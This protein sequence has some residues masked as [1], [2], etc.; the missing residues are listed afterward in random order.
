[1]NE[2]TLPKAYQ[3]KNL[4]R[5]AVLVCVT[6][7]HAGERLIQGGANI[8]AQKGCSLLV[9]SIQESSFHYASKSDALE[10]LFQVSTEYNA[11]MSVFYGSDP[12]LVA[13]NYISRR[14]VE[15]IVTGMPSDGGHFIINIQQ[16]FPDIPLSIIPPQGMVD[17]SFQDHVTPAEQE[18]FLNEHALSAVFARS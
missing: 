16:S 7:Q 3:E 18:S 11:D 12:I 8:A 6:D 10:H 5:P 4:H 15:H 2:K 1:M 9:L 17:I 13:N 14:Q